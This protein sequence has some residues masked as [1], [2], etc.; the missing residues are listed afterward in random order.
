ML[1]PNEYRCIFP[2]EMS[3]ATFGAAL[4]VTSPGELTLEAE[5]KPESIVSLA[6]ARQTCS[7]QNSPRPCM[8]RPGG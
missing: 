8:N 5:L 7:R 1:E 6:I 2:V 3:L 4:A